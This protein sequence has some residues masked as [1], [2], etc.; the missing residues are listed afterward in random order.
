MEDPKDPLEVAKKTLQNLLTQFKQRLAEEEDARAI[1]C[2]QAF[3]QDILA[4]QERCM[5][6]FD[7]EMMRLSQLKE[8]NP[9]RSALYERAEQSA[10]RQHFTS[11]T[12]LSSLLRDKI[13]Q[14]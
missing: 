12:F 5:Q 13:A 8:Q 10:R 1:E 9:A 14:S 11:M 7:S 3:E 2:A 6:E 4:R